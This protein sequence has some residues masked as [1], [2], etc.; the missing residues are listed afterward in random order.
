MLCPQSLPNTLNDRHLF[1]QKVQMLYVE[2]AS[3]YSGVVKMS[4]NKLKLKHYIATHTFHSAKVRKEFREVNSHRKKNSDWFGN[5]SIELKQSFFKL[6]KDRALV[7]GDFNDN[8]EVSDYALLYQMFYGRGDFFFCHWFAVDEQTIIDRLSSNGGDK[9]F[10]TMATQIDAPRVNI[11]VMR[12]YLE[13]L[14]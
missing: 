2:K 12:S 1:Y 11:K 5:E 9:F 3:M 6:L 8:F 13:K 14:S 7:E 4:T 10:A